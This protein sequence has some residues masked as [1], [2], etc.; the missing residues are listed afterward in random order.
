VEYRYT[1]ISFSDCNKQDEMREEAAR[2]V[3][4]FIQGKGPLEG[5]ADPVSYTV[6][7]NGLTIDK[8]T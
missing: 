1:G 6:L 2:C 7:G 4:D 8:T 3:V 5:Q